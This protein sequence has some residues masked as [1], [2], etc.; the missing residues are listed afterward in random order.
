MLQIWRGRAAMRWRH[1]L[2]APVS[3]GCSVPES[4]RPGRAVAGEGQGLAYL[5]VMGTQVERTLSLVL[6]MNLI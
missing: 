2:S 1:L 4:P 6:E 3:Q 5:S